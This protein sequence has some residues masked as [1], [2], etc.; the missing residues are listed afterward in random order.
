LARPRSFLA[1]L[2]VLNSN[3]ARGFHG[4]VRAAPN[5]PIRKLWGLADRPR[6]L[7]PSDSFASLKPLKRCGTLSEAVAASRR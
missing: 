4:S 5:Q 2:I 3:C 6:S 7:S 1:T